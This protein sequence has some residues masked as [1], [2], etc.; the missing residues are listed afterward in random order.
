MKRDV[1]LAFF[2]LHID[3]EAANFT[4]KFPANEIEVVI[5]LLEIGV[6]HDHLGESQGQKL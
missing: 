4:Q 1:L 2:G 5:L 3:D 6:E